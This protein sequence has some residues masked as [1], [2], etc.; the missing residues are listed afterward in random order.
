[1]LERARAGVDVR[2]IYDHFGNLV[3]PAAKKAFPEPIKTYV[4]RGLTR[5]WQVLDPRHYALEH[6]KVLVID[7]RTVFTGGFNIGGDY[8]RKWRDTHIRVEGPSVTNL[9]LSFADFWNAHVEDRDLAAPRRYAAM[10][11]PLIQVQVNDA[12]TLSFPIRDM[13][14][15]ALD[16]AERSIHLT[17]AY[18]APDQA[19]AGE[20]IDAARRGVDVQI[21]VPWV[22]NHVVMDWLARGYFDELLDAGARIFGYEGMIHAKTCTVD[23]IWSTVGTANLD[24]LSQWGNHELNLDIISEDLA[25]QLEDMFERDLQS[26]REIRRDEWKR[27]PFYARFAE[28]TLEPLRNLM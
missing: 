25:R 22:S 12:A 6:R 8:A 28:L 23:G 2:F 5:P 7:G 9:A 27:R 14:L 20:L 21:L 13:Y 19:M 26:A 18:F 4:H 17:S 24:R 15:R 10:F 16:M 11:D 1:M 3:V